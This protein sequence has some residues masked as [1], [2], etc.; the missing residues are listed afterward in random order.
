MEKIKLFIIIPAL[1][2]GGAEKVI[3][4]LCDNLNTEKFDLTLVV[5]NKIGAFSNYSN[6]NI[7]I[8]DLKIKHVRN[9]IFKLY[10]LI[11]DEK[12]DIVFTTLEHL[13]LLMSILKFFLP[14][15]IKFIARESSIVSLR[16]KQKKLN[17]L[18]DFLYKKFFNN[19]DTIIC[20]SNF[21]LEDLVNNYG[22]HKNK[23]KIINNPV[24]VNKIQKLSQE[25]SEVL[26]DKNT[27]NLIAVGRLNKVKQY[28]LMIEIV[29]Q[30]DS[31]YHLYILGTGAEE[32][33]L[34]KMVSDLNLNDRIH[35]LG[36][37]DNPYVFM[38]QADIILMTSK[39]EGFPNV[40]IEANSLGIPIVAFDNPGG[41]GEI[42]SDNLNGFLIQNNNIKD[43]ILKIKNYSNK[44]ID[45][46]RII[47]FIEKKYSVKYIVNKYENLFLELTK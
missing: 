10:K 28:H 23:M 4:T 45:K 32:V 41:I 33:F 19:F 8:I 15:S 43:F 3:L 31:K 22:I 17:Y 27:I 35:F 11:R 14:Q 13:N 40:L 39:Y 44:K 30:L 12:P 47:S 37:Q 18:F 1:G 46:E 6:D 2:G 16:N 5:I 36:F 24:D 26:L 7:K 38:K 9:S 20:Q 29:S 25:N 42:I 34:K 21:M